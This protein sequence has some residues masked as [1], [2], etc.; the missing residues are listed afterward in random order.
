MNYSSK[1]KCNNTI[2]YS[3]IRKR[4]VD[5]ENMSKVVNP[6]FQKDLGISLGFA[7][8]KQTLN[9]YVNS[10]TF[11]LDGLYKLIKDLALWINYMGEVLSITEFL[12]L[13]YE[14]KKKYY[15][16]F[17]IPKEME[18]SFKELKDTQIAHQR[19][20]LYLKHMEIQYKLFK[21]CFFNVN[22]TYNESLSSILY[23]TDI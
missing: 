8:Y 6:Y 19:L 7:G 13:K 14:N 18:D 5:F 23:R 2:P 21:G 11:D 10:E 4:A 20:S 16:S 15:L 1:S 17:N 22:K 3:V 12:C 9:D